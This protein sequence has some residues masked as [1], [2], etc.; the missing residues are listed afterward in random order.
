MYMLSLK[1]L[2]MKMIESM[3]KFLS[4]TVLPLRICLTF[5]SFRMH[6][7]EKMFEHRYCHKRFGNKN[8]AKRH[9]DS[10]HLRPH[11]WSCAA[12]S[13]READFYPSASLDWQMPNG[14]SDDVCGY[15]SKKFSN[16]SCDTTA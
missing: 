8:E 10:I 12:I 2:R 1:G 4:Q 16:F 7:K 15:C 9:E 3:F 5:C 11:L 13:D 6:M 14:P